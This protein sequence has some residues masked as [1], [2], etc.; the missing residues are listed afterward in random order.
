MTRRLAT[1]LTVT[2]ASSLGWGVAQGVTAQQ[3][4]AH[5]K[6]DSARTFGAEETFLRQ[7]TEVLRLAA[8]DHSGG[9]I[10]MAPRYQGRVM[11]S[12]L[13]GEHGAS[14]G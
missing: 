5:M 4:P 6:S 9:E 11:T 2:L 7:H 12:S 3:E 14:L 8:P 13:A 1:I 10:L